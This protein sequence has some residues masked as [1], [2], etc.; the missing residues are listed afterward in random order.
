M[1]RRVDHVW[2]DV[3]EER[4]ASIFKAENSQARIQREQVAANHT[5]NTSYDTGSKAWTVFAR[6][7]TGIVGSNPIHGMNVWC[8][9]AFVVCLCRPVFR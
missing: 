6:S 8:V 1:W 2:T 9:Y 3:S 7:N 5:E 4:I